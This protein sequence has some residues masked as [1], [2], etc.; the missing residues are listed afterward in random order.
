MYPEI[1]LDDPT[2]DFGGEKKVFE[3]LRDCLPDD[4]HIFHDV[5]KYKVEN[6]AL[7]ENE[8]DFVIYNRKKGIICLEVKN[9]NF[10]YNPTYETSTGVHVGA[11][12]RH[13][14]ELMS[15]RGPW[16]QA[17]METK[18]FR[19]LIKEIPELD[20]MECKFLYAVWAMKFTNN[21]ATTSNWPPEAD[22]QITFFLD[23]V[24]AA[25]KAIENACGDLNALRISNPLKDR[26][27]K[28]FDIRIETDYLNSQGEWKKSVITN[29]ISDAEEKILFSKVLL[30]EF[31]IFD[32]NELNDINRRRKSVQFLAK[33]R[34]VLDYT[35]LQQFVAIDGAAGTGKTLVA[36]KK[37]SMLGKE[38]DVSLGEKVIFLGLN[39]ELIKNLASH[40]PAG[41]VVYKTIDSFI[42][43]DLCGNKYTSD[44]PAKYE[45]AEDELC[46]MFDGEKP[47]PYKHFIIDE[48]Q[49]FAS[50]NLN[51]R[52][53]LELIA[54]AIQEQYYE[55]C[56]YVFYDE[57]QRVNGSKNNP[58]PSYINNSQEK[59]SLLV[60]CRNTTNIALAS[61]KPMFISI[62]KIKIREIEETEISPTKKDRRIKIEKHRIIKR[63]EMTKG[64]RPGS[65]VYMYYV[66]SGKNA[67]KDAVDT[68]IRKLIEI[69]EKDIVVLTCKSK[70]TSLFREEDK[71]HPGSYKLPKWKVDDV[72]VRFYTS[73]DFKGMEANNVILVEVDKDTY[74]N[75]PMLFYVGASRAKNSLAIVA[76]LTN[77]DCKSLLDNW[78]Q[79]DEYRN[80]KKAFADEMKCRMGTL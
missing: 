64:T 41:N 58:L 45:E 56:F 6:N 51:E 5:H 26:I 7:Q 65:F 35:S 19:D 57:L 32:R 18:H 17:K 11:W 31:S 1:Y 20:S 61:L 50:P 22:Q 36:V 27:E 25:E 39:E 28:I 66:E 10:K 47:L 13:N 78:V 70:E 12:V 9:S 63:M 43:E 29:S 46:R 14:G 77:D 69:N 79:I 53:I 71:K 4:Y 74:E 48:C 54:G 55:G 59:T 34:Q 3:L 16:H 21:R 23:D 15:H 52:N 76:N 8:C 30:N 67:I 75:E 60:N 2:K 62:G 40:Y 44:N 42:L 37:A 68:L 33:Q 38:C 24:E 73:G 72:S 49:D 80:P